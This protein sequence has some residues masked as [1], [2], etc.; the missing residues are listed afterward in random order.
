M[1]NEPHLHLAEPVSDLRLSS[2]LTARVS[3]ALCAALRYCSHAS[4]TR[5][6]PQQAPTARY[7]ACAPTTGTLNRDLSPSDIHSNIMTDVSDGRTG[8]MPPR[9]RSNFAARTATDASQRLHRRSFAQ[10]SP[11]PNERTP[12]LDGVHEPDVQEEDHGVEWLRSWFCNTFHLSRSKSHSSS[13]NGNRKASSE[14]PKP[15]PGA[16]PRPVGGTDKLG[17]FAGVFVPVTLNVLSILMF[18]RF[19]FILGQTGVVGM[20]GE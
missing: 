6:R 12:L 15:R 8:R 2:S 7:V 1:P 13:Q 9:S 10:N 3:A 20:M 4:I 5:R 18:L 16:F 17:T 19:G 11:P 14:A